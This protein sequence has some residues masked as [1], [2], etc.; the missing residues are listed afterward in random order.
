MNPQDK[1]HFWVSENT[2]NSTGITVQRA[3]AVRVK[4]F[5]STWPQ[6]PLRKKSFIL[7]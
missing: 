5:L 1:P 2:F 3:A 7:K 4:G 6:S